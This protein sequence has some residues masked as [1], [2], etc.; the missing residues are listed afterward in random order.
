VYTFGG[1]TATRHE[2]AKELGIT[3]HTLAY[4]VETWGLER[5]L[6]TPGTEKHSREAMLLRNRLRGKTLFVGGQEVTLTDLARRFGVARSS[7]GPYIKR[8]GLEAALAHYS[9][10]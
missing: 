5:A 7:I 1:K 9:R 4:R 6:T 3:H 8:Y 10:Q 2:W